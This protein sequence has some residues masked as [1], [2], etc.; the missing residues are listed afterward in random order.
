MGQNGCLWGLH[1]VI[2]PVISSTTGSKEQNSK[3]MRNVWV[4]QSVFIRLLWGVPNFGAADWW[5]LN[6]SL[7]WRISNVHCTTACHPLQFN[8]LESRLT[9]SLLTCHGSA[10]WK[11]KKLFLPWPYPQGL[12]L[13]IHQHQS[14]SSFISR[15]G[16]HVGWFWYLV[17]VSLFTQHH[18][19]ENLSWDCPMSCLVKF[20]D[21]GQEIRHVLKIPQNLELWVKK[22][23]WLY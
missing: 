13:T 11:Q 10:E 23:F 21:T 14:V 18:L 5:S 22:H 9:P 7:G 8:S 15:Y 20:D 1:L 17:S 12:L 4:C 19:I 16:S 2:V 3:H 6:Q